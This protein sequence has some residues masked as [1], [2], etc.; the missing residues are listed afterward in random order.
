M[1]GLCA[2]ALSYLAEIQDKIEGDY[3]DQP[4]LTVLSYQYLA[5]GWGSWPFLRR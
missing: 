5:R 3:G 4:F 1:Q 2:T